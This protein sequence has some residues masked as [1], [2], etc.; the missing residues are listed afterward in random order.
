MCFRYTVSTNPLLL[1]SKIS[2]FYP[3]SLTVQPGLCWTWSEHKLLVFLCTGSIIHL[4]LSGVIHRHDIKQ[5][6]V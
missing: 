2:S 5:D 6:K 4:C 3:F 1:I